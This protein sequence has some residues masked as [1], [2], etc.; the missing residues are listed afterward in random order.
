MRYYSIPFTFQHVI[1]DDFSNIKEQTDT[2]HQSGSQLFGRLS[3]SFVYRGRDPPLHFLHIPR[4]R[5][6]FNRVHHALR[7]MR[8]LF[9]SALIYHDTR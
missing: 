7:Q 5:T 8:F 6:E 3:C 4:I 9:E 2:A 1:S